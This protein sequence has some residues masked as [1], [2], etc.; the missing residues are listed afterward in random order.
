MKRRSVVFSVLAGPTLAMASGEDI[1]IESVMPGAGPCGGYQTEEQEGEVGCR[2]RAGR[3]DCDD[4]SPWF[5]NRNYRINRTHLYKYYQYGTRHLCT[6]WSETGS[7]CNT[8]AE[9]PCPASNC[10]L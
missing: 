10:V 9:P 4:G 6:P 3:A 8:I 5:Y 2:D 7:C 1:W